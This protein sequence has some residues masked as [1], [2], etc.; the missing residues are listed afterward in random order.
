MIDL[1]FLEDRSLLLDFQKISRQQL[2]THENHFQK[3]NV[4]KNRPFLA[5][6]RLMALPPTL[7]NQFLPKNTKKIP[8]ISAH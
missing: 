8:E 7:L 4:A 1:W 6:E 5:P 2:P 3:A